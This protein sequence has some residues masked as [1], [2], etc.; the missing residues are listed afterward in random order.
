MGLQEG[1][2]GVDHST[3]RRKKRRSPR[4]TLTET[5]RMLGFPRF[6]RG[7]WRR[8]RQTSRRRKK[9][10]NPMEAL[11]VP[12]PGEGRNGVDDGASRRKKRKS[13]KKT[14]TETLRMLGVPGVLLKIAHRPRRHNR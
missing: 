12:A 14:L 8:K 3:S 10:T 1:R 11:C 7:P 5:L 9:L 4:K 6:L 13:P 2:S